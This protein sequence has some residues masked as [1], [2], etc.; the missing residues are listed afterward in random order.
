MKT[1]KTY[2]WANEWIN[3]EQGGC[4]DRVYA[5]S[6]KDLE[7]PSPT[8][9]EHGRIRELALIV[10]VKEDDECID[11]QWAYVRHGDLPTHFEEGIPVPGRFQAELHSFLDSNL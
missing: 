5:H 4:D 6:V 2:I 7:L 1:E 3:E 8:R 9:D 11:Q 10:D